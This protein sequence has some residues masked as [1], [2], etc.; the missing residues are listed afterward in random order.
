[1]R[2][3]HGSIL[4]IELLFAMLITTTLM[5]MATVSFVKL[6]AAQNTV[7]AKTRLRQVA[8]A[9]AAEVTCNQ[10]S[11][12]VVPTALTNQIPAYGVIQQSGY[13]YTMTDLG[14][15]NWDYVAAPT[16]Q[17]FTGAT[18]FYISGDI[19]L[20]CAVGTVSAASPSCQ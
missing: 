15:G 16:S 2:K 17:G 12:C 14:G 19:V 1:M 9:V 18:S 7:D 20:R 6:R 10:T 3:Q 5:A 4:L 8:N 11:G 13:T